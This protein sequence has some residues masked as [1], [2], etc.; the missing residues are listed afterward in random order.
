MKH[1]ALSRTGAVA[2]LCMIGSA[3]SA[4]PY[5]AHQRVQLF[6]TCAGRFEA[7][8]L[9]H[10]EMDRSRRDTMRDQV[11]G[12]QTLVDAILPDALAEEMP[13]AMPK[14]WRA[15]GWSE[16]AHL[17]TEVQ[18]SVDQGRIDRAS[19]ILETRIKECEGLLLS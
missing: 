12:F 1:N 9:D 17:L 15:T 19:D 5:W 11:Q 7:M 3:P 2:L 10:R 13:E 6:A 14:Q 16:V 18:Y 8:S 4:L